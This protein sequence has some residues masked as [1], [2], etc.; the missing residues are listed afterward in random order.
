MYRLRHMGNPPLA[1]RL[2]GLRGAAGLT[3]EQLAAKAQISLA[4]IIEIETGKRRRPHIRTMWR[5]AE[6]LGVD[7]DDL[8][9]EAS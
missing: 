2:R 6:A 4:T 5:L 8:L 7:L 3:Q 1:T 9:E